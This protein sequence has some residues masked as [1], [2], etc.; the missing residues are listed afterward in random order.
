M[1]GLR[2]C[3]GLGCG[4]KG[5]RLH[6]LQGAGSLVGVRDRDQHILAWRVHTVEIKD[7]SEC[8]CLPWRLL[9]GG[10]VRGGWEEGTVL[11]AKGRGAQ[12]KAVR[13]LRGAGPAEGPFR[14]ELGCLKGHCA[15]CW[16]VSKK[17]EV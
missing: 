1:A 3:S 8:L 11:G 17:D 16:G 15:S 2:V 10:G 9:E 12:I 7:R 13:A 6:N 4:D 14:A 5:H